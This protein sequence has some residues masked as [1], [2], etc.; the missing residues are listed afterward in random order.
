[1]APTLLSQ[2][3]TKLAVPETYAACAAVYIEL[4]LRSF[5][6][7]ELGIIVK[8]LVSHMRA[9]LREPGNNGVLPPAAL[10][11]IERI[12]TLL[13]QRGGS[14][15]AKVVSSDEFIALLDLFHGDRKVSFCKSFLKVRAFVRA[16]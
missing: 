4:M 2:T 5:G 10:P 3:I 15:V 9:A 16:R 1:M 14:D 6:E 12:M 11:H 8:D 13:M 7:R